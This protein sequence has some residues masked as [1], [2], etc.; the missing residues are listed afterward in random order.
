MSCFVSAIKELRKY[1]GG[2][3]GWNRYTF[4]K[5]SIS[6]K[7]V[8]LRNRR[9]ISKSSGTEGIGE[10]YP[11]KILYFQKVFYELENTTIIKECLHTEQ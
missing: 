3:A 9:N 5:I 11:I 7:G 8:V 1:D 10:G 4:A 2:N 6:V